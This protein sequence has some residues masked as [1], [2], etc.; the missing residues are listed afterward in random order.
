[1]IIEVKQKY[2]GLR[3][4]TRF[5]QDMTLIAT[6]RIKLRRKMLGEEERWEKKNVGK[7][8][9]LEKEGRWEKKEM[10]KKYGNPKMKMYI[11]V[12]TM[13]KVQCNNY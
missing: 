1:M 9:T 8:R 11:E 7:K 12:A 13:E 5:V 3:K 2:I 10:L 4:R 6:T